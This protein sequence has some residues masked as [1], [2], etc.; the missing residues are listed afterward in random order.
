MPP[1]SRIEDLSGSD[2]VR[3]ADDNFVTHAT[4]GLQT[5]P[6]ATVHAD[7]G[8][9]LADSGLPCDAFNVVCRARLTVEAA[10]E[11]ARKTVA[12]FASAGRAFSWWVGPAD[13]PADLPELLRRAGLSEAGS[14]RLLALD[15]EVDLDLQS[16]GKPPAIP[17]FE[18]R[19]VASRADLRNYALVTASA[20]GRDPN[21]A[22]FYELAAASLLRSDSPRRLF[23]GYV[24]GVPVATAEWTA[25]RGAAGLY[26]VATEPA[27]RRKGIGSALTIHALRAARA[28]GE[29]LAILQAAPAAERLY[30]R[31]G[32]R[33]IGTILEFKPKN[34]LPGPTREAL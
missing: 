5:L 33:P 23:A 26:N 13:T 6:G 29:T 30:A 21:I 7:E 24:G 11:R 22:R 4:W 9:T 14:E 34:G 8:L 2:V 32:F 3:A 1:A 31:L 10:V 20:A 12:Y 28:E 27:H 16:S 25:A 15:L 18:I 17:D 19:P